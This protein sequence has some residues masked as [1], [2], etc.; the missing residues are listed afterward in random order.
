MLHM[1]SRLDLETFT[2]RL[3]DGTITPDASAAEVSGT[4]K[5]KH[6]SDGGY[7]RGVPGKGSMSSALPV[8]AGDKAG[9]LAAHILAAAI[10]FYRCFQ[11]SEKVDAAS[12]EEELKVRFAAHTR[13]QRAGLLE[14]FR[15]AT[16][17]CD[18]LNA[19][20]NDNDE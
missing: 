20:H 8:V 5:S 6:Q 10:E 3:E 2:E 18:V 4:K 15:Y 1:V 19:A 13:E 16:E 12:L 7:A 9:E 14:G 11:A 17:W